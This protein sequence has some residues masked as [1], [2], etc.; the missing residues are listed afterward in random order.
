[1]LVRL[2]VGVA[3]PVRSFPLPEE[4]V[5][6]EVVLVVFENALFGRHVDGKD[7]MA[8]GVWCRW[9]R[10]VLDRHPLKFPLATN[11]G[12]RWTEVLVQRV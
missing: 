9:R 7:W 10:F 8:C 6:S 1:M 3:L 12:P 11:V 5:R 4:Q 2:V